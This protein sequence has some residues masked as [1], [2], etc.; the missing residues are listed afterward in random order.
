M[1]IC[2]LCDKVFARWSVLRD[3]IQKGRCAFLDPQLALSLPPSVVVHPP[4][5]LTPAEHATG[6]SVSE[7]VIPAP[8]EISSGRLPSVP[9]AMLSLALHVPGPGSKDQARQQ[10]WQMQVGQLSSTPILQ[11]DEVLTLARDRGWQQLITI[12]LAYVMNSGIIVHVVGSGV[13]LLLA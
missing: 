8:S 5:P 2:A 10:Q 12:C 1:P 13:L 4:C 7:Q 11:R 6:L 9:P 3:H